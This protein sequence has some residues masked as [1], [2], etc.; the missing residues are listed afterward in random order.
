MVTCPGH[1]HNYE[2]LSQQR[3]VE[4]FDGAKQISTEQIKTKIVS[5]NYVKYSYQN[6]EDS[7]RS[8]RS[9]RSST[10]V[11]LLTITVD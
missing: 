9:L 2:A 10:Q 4:T 6:C 8:V 7:S 5:V 3:R 1:R 11:N